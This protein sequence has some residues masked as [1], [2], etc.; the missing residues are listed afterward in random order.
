MGNRSYK[1]ISCCT[2]WPNGSC[3]PGNSRVC[4]NWEDSDVNASG[5]LP[6]QILNLG[7]KTF[8][9]SQRTMSVLYCSPPQYIT[10][11]HLHIQN[12]VCNSHIYSSFATKVAINKT[13][14]IIWCNL[15]A[16]RYHVFYTCLL[17]TSP[18]P[19]D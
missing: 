10:M 5:S 3:Q 15:Q 9:A 13:F 4:K 19:R 18:S 11:V 12:I 16:T 8:F 2:L 7:I 6:L 1:T 14:F 17:Y